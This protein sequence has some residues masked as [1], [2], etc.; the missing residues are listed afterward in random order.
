MLT[1]LSQ[2]QDTVIGNGTIRDNLN[3]LKEREKEKLPDDYDIQGG[4]F[5]LVRLKSL[6]DFKLEPFVKEGIISATLDNGQVVLSPRSVLKLNCNYSFMEK[7]V[8]LRET[9]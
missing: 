7:Y 5:G 2:I 4:A 9:L 3:L 8:Y 1:I 6:Y